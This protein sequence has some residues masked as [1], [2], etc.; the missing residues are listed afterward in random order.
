MKT[1]FCEQG[2]VEW[3]RLRGKMPTASCFKN[4][5]T[6]TGAPSKSA[7]SYIY[8]LLAAQMGHTED[9]DSYWIDRG[10]ELESAARAAY[11]FLT[12]NEVE[13]I[14]FCMF[15][16]ENAGCSPDGLIDSRRS[17]I[18]LKCPAPHTHVEWLIKEKL[19]AAH[20][21]QVQGSMWITGT[22]K[23]DFMSYCPGLPHILLTIER[24]EDFL[25]KLAEQ[26]EKFN[27]KLATERAKLV[28]RGLLG[29]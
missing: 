11:E 14:G 16:S 25:S 12:D 9:I 28:E 17:G 10:N 3:F 13:E 29:E 21:Q 26:V 23:W 8:K 19:P 27:E 18:E 22:N 5:V 15:D 1:I 20:V 2:S 7:N 6:S 4:I 24:D